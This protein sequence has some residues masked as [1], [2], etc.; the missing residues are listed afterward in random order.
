M[1]G[2]TTRIEYRACPN[3]G[4]VTSAAKCAG[5]GKELPPSTS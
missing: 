3:C 5:C 1:A 2:K 4:D